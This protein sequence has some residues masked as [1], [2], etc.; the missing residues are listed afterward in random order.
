[1]WNI[2]G[3]ID[4]IEE[5]FGEYVVRWRWPVILLSVAICLVAAAGL[6]NIVLD[7]T[8]RNFFEKDYSLLVEFDRLEVE[9]SDS[10]GLLL[11]LD[12]QEA[13]AA[14]KRENLSLIKRVTEE[15]WQT[16][17]S[18]R[19][20]SVTNFQ[21]ISAH[22]DDLNVD[23]LVPGEPALLSDEQLQNIKE[24]ALAEPSIVRQTLS[25][26]GRVAAVFISLN[27]INES[28][29]ERTEVLAYLRELAARYESG[30]EKVRIYLTGRLSVDEGMMN[31]L[32]EDIVSVIPLAGIMMLLFMLALTRS[33]W[34]TVM[35]I[36]IIVMSLVCG[37]G[38][39]GHLG[40][41]LGGPSVIA[42]IAILT[43]AAASSVHLLM[44]FLNL[45]RSGTGVRPAIN[46]A[47]RL[48][49]QPITLT[50]LS[51]TIGFLS[52]LLS[53][54]PA[55]R[56]MAS[57]VA[58]GVMC[59]L[60]W[61]MLFLPAVMSFLP[62]RSGRNTV[63]SA[64][65]Q[66][67][68]RFMHSL[69]D[70]VVRYKTP[71][72]VISAAFILLMVSGVSRLSLNDDMV[73]H[74]APG[75]PERV[76]VDFGN[77]H[78]SSFYTL[79]YELVGSEAGAALTPVFLGELEQYANWL[80]DQP[81]VLHVLSLSDVMKRLNR[82]MH[83]EQLEWYQIPDSRELAAQYFLLYEMS[84]PYGLDANN[85]VNA[86]RSASR[87]VVNLSSMKSTQLIDFE[88][89]VKE[90]Q[91]ENFTV[92]TSGVGNGVFAMFG[93]VSRVNAI[94][95]LKV[96]VIALFGISI[97]LIF[98]LRSFRMGFI[99]IIPNLVPAAMGFGLWGFINGEVNIVISLI[100]TMTLG[101]VVD[102]SVHFMSKYNRARTEQ[103]MS[104][105]EAVIYSF[106]SVGQALVV[107]SL[108]LMAGFMSLYFSAFQPNISIGILTS[109]VISFAL[110]ADFFFLP[111]I[112]LFLD[113]D[114]ASEMLD[115]TESTAI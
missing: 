9:Y 84:L 13:N 81:E 59:S 99:S 32:A 17:H 101:I 20:D 56:V 67:A 2:F 87:V 71:V 49:L 114:K 39:A 28:D 64:S 111:P 76:A 98:M 77:E 90:W 62:E 43:V 78:L 14:F 6:K 51:T 73:E 46:E 36:F 110:I 79:Q 31:S 12:F 21:N 66:H 7:T 47:V 100:A 102:D 24:I 85:I 107:T 26:D 80:R 65:H 54:V 106:T 61:V 53:D 93:K 33:V 8:Y 88:R 4:A 19:V 52:I 58:F 97:L 11:M 72:F 57:I 41:E 50:S 44:S 86:D 30:S 48:N 89:R 60:L 25:A 37:L 92:I 94:S 69:G 5:H 63:A 18:L 105:N 104:A 113:R 70:F 112:L 23:D 83:G 35:T 3:W 16:P 10:E 115:D 22:A 103:G 68:H 40:M 95:M 42:P 55:F 74:L 45:Q 1:M 38:A 82:S 96:T 29:S 27:K 108:M 75:E 34:A 15:A 109:I 91:S